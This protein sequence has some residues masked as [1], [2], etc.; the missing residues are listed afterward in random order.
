MK[1]MVHTAVGASFRMETAAA[2]AR[3][4]SYLFAG[5]Q[6][7]VAVRVLFTKLDRR[8]TVE[9]YLSVNRRLCGRTRQTV[10]CAAY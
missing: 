10:R 2:S 5:F 3:L 7:P 8:W 1:L 6:H 4:R 9:P